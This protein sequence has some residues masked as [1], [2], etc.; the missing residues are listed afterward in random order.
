MAA[1]LVLSKGQRAEQVEE[2]ADLLGR[3]VVH[4]VQ[5]ALPETPP[6]VPLRLG[7]VANGGFLLPEAAP[8]LTKMA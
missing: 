7:T 1:V 5:D 4:V 3:Q 2:P 6:S 8:T